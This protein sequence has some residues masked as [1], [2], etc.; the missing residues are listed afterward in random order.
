MLSLM[1]PVEIEDLV[2]FRD[3]EDARKFYLLPDRPVI[4]LDDQ[5]VPEFLFIKYIKDLDSTP[6]TADVG[7]GWVQFRS[8]LT[9]DP[10]REKRVKDAL[11]TRLQEGKAAG[12]QPFGHAIASTDPLLAAPLWTDGKVS[13]ATFKASDTGL[14]R[15]ATDTVAADLAGDLGASLALE[16][17]PNGAEIFW[18]A[19]QGAT[20][21]Q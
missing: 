2:V 9:L 18:S 1:D 8:T 3:D 7:G 17:D 21:Q 6:D 14:V 16:L 5:G 4:P 12:K 11:H 13:L 20:E 15:H 10:A 19:F